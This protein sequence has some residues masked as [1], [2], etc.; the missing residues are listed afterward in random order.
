M[1]LWGCFECYDGIGL[2]VCCFFVCLFVLF[3]FFVKDH[4]VSNPALIND[5]YKLGACP[6]DAAVAC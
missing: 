1:E 3:V 4:S 5:P 2:L 6:G